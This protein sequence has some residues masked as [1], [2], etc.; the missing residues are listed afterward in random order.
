MSAGINRS[1]EDQKLLTRDEE[2][3]RPRNTPDLLTPVQM[4]LQPLDLLISCEGAAPL[5]AAELVDPFRELRYVRLVND[6]RWNDDLPGFGDGGFVAADRQRHQFDRLIAKL[7]RL[8]NSARAVDRTVADTDQRLISLVESHNLH[9]PD[10]LG[11][12]HRIEDGR[13]VVT[14]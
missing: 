1:L 14:P 13:T 12:L 2:I 5:S 10:L 8:L 11:L 3:R 9:F 6:E 4:F 7:V